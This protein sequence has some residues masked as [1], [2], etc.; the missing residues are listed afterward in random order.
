[1]K[2]IALLSNV[3]IDPVAIGLR[4]RNVDVWAPDGYGDI[5]GALDEGEIKSI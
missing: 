3:N 1:V 2:R 5:F 4:R